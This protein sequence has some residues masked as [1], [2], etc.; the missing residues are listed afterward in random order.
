MTARPVGAADKVTGRARYVAD[1]VLPGMAYAA[2]VRSTQSHARII[3]IDTAA[4]RQ[5]DG[6]VGVFTAA[7]T[8]PTL[9]GRS[10]VDV[11]VLAREKV[12]FVGER[13]AAVVAET[14]AQAEAAAAQVVIDYEP[15]PAVH[16]AEDALRPDAPAVHDQ[17][18]AYQGA[19]ASPGGPPNVIY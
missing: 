11:P 12:R 2:M 13:V 15:L 14:R 16:T 9:Y 10:V 1:I 19:V 17:P 8:V 18:W 3:R 5:M 7:D 6:V 4:A